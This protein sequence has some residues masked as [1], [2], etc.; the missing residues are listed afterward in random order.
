M[1]DIK[2]LKKVTELAEGYLDTFKGDNDYNTCN[3][4]SDDEATI[5]AAKDALAEIDEANDN[6]EA[7]RRDPHRG[8]G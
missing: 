4:W 2:A 1:V 5:K 6:N 3:D 7:F 8:E